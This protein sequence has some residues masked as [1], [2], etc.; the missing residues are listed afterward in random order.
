MTDFI[1][2]VFEITIGMSLF[3]ALLLIGL[4]LFGSK[5]TAKCR[6]IIWA[7]VMI[8]LAIPF[9]FGLLP[10]LI[11]IP[12]ETELVQSEDL[13][14]VLSENT[15]PVTSVQPSD[16]GNIAVNPTVPSTPVFPNVDSVNPD[17]TPILP[18]EQAEPVIPSEPIVEIPAEQPIS[19]KQILDIA[20]IVYLIGAAGFLVWSLVS[21]FIYTRKILRSAKAA[22]ERTQQIFSTIC[23]KY[24]IKKQPTLLV[25]SGIHS[26]AAF[27]IFR[28]KIVLPDIAFSEN[29]LV[30]TLAHEVTHCK[31]GDLY[32]KLV[33]LVTCSLNWFNPLV[34]IAAF[35][36]EME[37]ELSCDEKVLSGSSEATRAAYADVM[38]D[39]IRRCRRNR[40]ALTTHFNP[41]K[42][43]VTARFKN[44]LYGSGKRR[45][46]ILI[47]VCLVLCVLA[48]T[49]VACTI[50]DN[51]A[52]DHWYAEGTYL[53]CDNDSDVIVI[54]AEGANPASPCKMTAADD[55][56]SFE[57]LTDG[58]RIKV[59]ISMIMT[60][61]PGQTD[62]YS[63]EKLS[64]G[65]RDDIDPAVMESLRELGWID[66][67]S[68]QKELPNYL[69]IPAITL[70]QIET[71]PYSEETAVF[72]VSPVGGNPTIFFFD[73]SRTFYFR[74]YLSTDMD[75]EYFTGTLTLPD[76]FTDPKLLHVIRGAGSGEIFVSIETIYDGQKEYLTYG[77]FGMEAPSGVDV[78]DEVQVQ[79]LME[80]LEQIT[81]E[82]DNTGTDYGQGPFIGFVESKETPWI[83]LYT[84]KDGIYVGRIPYEIFHDWVATDRDS[85]GWT[86]GWE[87]EYVHFYYAEFG[88]FRWAAAHLTNTVMGNGRKN[89]ATSSDGG[90]TW[91]YGSTA[92]DY[93][94]N[95]VVGIGFVS[96]NIAFM[97]FDP[98][99]EFDGADGPV[100]SRTV[101]GGKT[102]ELLD[103]SVPPALE[104][105]KLIAGI[106]YYSRN[107]LF[108]P[109]WL[110]TSHGEIEGEP[111]YLVSRDN[112]LTWS[113]DSYSLPAEM[114]QYT[115]EIPMEDE[116]DFITVAGVYGKG[117]EPNYPDG[118]TIH[119]GKDGT[120][121][122]VMGVGNDWWSRGNFK[123]LRTY[124]VTSKS[125][126]L[127]SVEE[128]E[129]FTKDKVLKN[130]KPYTGELDGMFTCLAY[131]FRQ[132]NFN[133]DF[134]SHSIYIQSD[135]TIYA[136]AGMVGTGGPIS[137][138]GTYQYDVKT[139]DFTAKLTGRYAS[140]GD[141]TIYPESEVKGKLYEYG[142]FVHF[143]CE[144][145]GVSTLTVND[146]IPLTFV[147]NTDGYADPPTVVLDN[148]F[149]GVWEYNDTDNGGKDHYR[150][151][152][153]TQTAQVQ[154][155]DLISGSLY[156]GT[157][158]VNPL[159]MTK[160]AKLRS[161]SSS[162]KESEF[163]L[164]FMLGYSKGTDGT[165][166]YFDILTCDAPS[167]Q[168]LVGKM[169]A[170][171]PITDNSEILISTEWIQYTEID[172]Q[173]GD[174][175]SFVIPESW[176]HN[177]DGI[178]HDEK[179]NKRIDA[180]S[181]HSNYPVSSFQEDLRK[182][183]NEK[184]HNLDYAI[185]GTNNAKI[186]Y[187]GYHVSVNSIGEA[188]PSNY[189]FCLN[190]DDEA[191]FYINIYGENID[192]YHT[193]Y[194]QYVLPIIQSVTVRETGVQTGQTLK[195]EELYTYSLIP[196]NTTGSLVSLTMPA[197][198]QWDGTN[199]NEANVRIGVYSD[200][201]R[202]SLY[203]ALPTL[204]EFEAA[205]RE[206][207]GRV[208]QMD[209][210]ITGKSDTG[211][212]FTGYYG[213]EEMPKGE[214]SR[215]YLF[216][217]ATDQGAYELEVWQRLD[218]DGADFLEE[219]VL[220][221]LQSFAI[222]QTLP[223]QAIMDH[224]SMLYDTLSKEDMFLSDWLKNNEYTVSK[225]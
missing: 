117:A 87:P 168:H 118:A 28:R 145:S 111:M 210:P 195:T 62:V 43:A 218:F 190:Y 98:H 205:L 204:Q 185:V 120:L 69:E 60:T 100:I 106:P 189:Y 196:R 89:V 77:F 152:I 88:D 213:D 202:V 178:L 96:E 221:I 1:L 156:E 121:Y 4:K 24:G 167:Y 72:T 154:M 52:D 79:R 49:I 224:Q 153:N 134:W 85:E 184:L 192:N 136:R 175:L 75:A 222:Q 17:N 135:G 25:A 5:F 200:Q 81:A 142:G 160:T 208:Y 11:E 119:A 130:G 165:F 102:W 19:L 93:G 53:K 143:V 146:K 166:L 86:P 138:E 38:L 133:Y 92:D 207:T 155:H 206:S 73:D 180:F 122:Y 20:G 29:G 16:P 158:T 186:G 99:N 39:I 35:K 74:N 76:G 128:V 40:G 82:P 123:A 126:Y 179:G 51:S 57:G 105:K 212:S 104:G 164:K 137:Y 9:S 45:G 147:P 110:N 116:R 18:G 6:Y 64:D 44:I 37:M 42:S 141:V 59:E 67:T 71:L 149:D 171:R 139:G 23:K 183:A 114:T 21:Y 108:Y 47:A 68:N 66:D 170:M 214:M 84:E 188:G 27:G 193:F 215:R 109:V 161:L 174:E 7:L 127:E 225:S 78:L 216:Y 41:K 56:V 172:E 223:H 115:V 125:G 65:E 157:Y 201:K 31:R 144:S 103:I 2:G 8:R 187:I 95:H 150:L 80:A 162:G 131:R 101:D 113:W 61:Y 194:D 148:T 182:M 151:S 220:P 58:D 209:S 217:I 15:D 91:N 94:G 12:I 197:A 10:T 70:T 177:S 169:L 54:D 203:G 107:E 22:D 90:K 173:T 219:T 46:W 132:G 176:N 13:S 48:G 50:G 32:M 14:S 34:H 63:I 140:E 33:E 191:R 124:R 181:F 129:T 55:S 36:C 112:G 26:P 159:N 97:S 211:Y 163:S 3:I 198:W 83:Q 30:G 199:F